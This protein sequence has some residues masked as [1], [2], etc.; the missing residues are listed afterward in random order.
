MKTLLASFLSL[1]LCIMAQAQ[2]PTD[3]EKVATLLSGR[4]NPG[5]QEIIASLGIG[6][7]D[8]LLTRLN[9][10]QDQNKVPVYC[11]LIGLKYRQFSEHL[12]PKKRTEIIML[13][14]SKI[15]AIEDNGQTAYLIHSSLDHLHGINDPAVLQLIEFYSKSGVDWTRKAAQ[16]LRGS[17][18]GTGSKPEADRQ[19]L[20]AEPESEVPT[21]VEP[22]AQEQ[23]PKSKP[24]VST[25]I[26]E[27]G[28]S[29]PWNFILVLVVAALGLLW[30]LLKKRR[31]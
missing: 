15:R 4:K 6:S 25:P 7:L 17:L 3:D 24:T 19:P 8:S 2:H 11:R 18:S 29:M 1:L 16:S 14:C 30:L 20:E 13:L 22:L 21:L 9:G 27:L 28:S 5:D 10:E 31:S 26:A 23:A 12:T